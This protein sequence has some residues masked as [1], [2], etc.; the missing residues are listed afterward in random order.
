MAT[1]D[2]RTESTTAV[3]EVDGTSVALDLSFVHFEPERA[4]EVALQPVVEDEPRPRFLARTATNSPLS[5]LVTVEVSEHSRPLPGEQQ[6]LIE[7]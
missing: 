4:R 7:G 3:I 6:P 2:L 1:I 5:P